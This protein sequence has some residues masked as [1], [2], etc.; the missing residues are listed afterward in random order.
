M[1]VAYPI[2]LTPMSEADGGGWLVTFPDWGD[3]VTDGDNPAEAL[4]N[5][6][7]CLETMI[8]YR[9][10]KCCDIPDPSAQGGRHLIVPGS[11]LATK[12][13]LWRAFRASGLTAVELA[14]RLGLAPDQL[15]KQLFHP[16]ARPKPDLIRAAAAALGKRVVVEVLDAA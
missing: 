5:A 9:L 2:D 3:A 11:D 14:T 7:D 8:D 12:A 10:R 1:R 6:V 15:H 16:R 13:A 4:T